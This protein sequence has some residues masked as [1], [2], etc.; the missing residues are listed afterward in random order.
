MLITLCKKTFME[1]RDFNKMCLNARLIEIISYNR[2][3]MDIDYP[4]G[5]KTRECELFRI[6]RSNPPE[7]LVKEV[8]NEIKTIIPCNNFYKIKVLNERRQRNFNNRELIILYSLDMKVN[9][10]DH[11]IKFMIEYNKQKDMSTLFSLIR[12]HIKKE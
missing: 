12:S 4:D 8:T 1:T 9:F 2:I 6:L 7:P 11:L 10:N 5:T 3:I